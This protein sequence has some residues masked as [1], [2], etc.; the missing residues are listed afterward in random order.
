MQ[1]TIETER[2]VDGRWIAEVVEISGA[3][4]YGDTEQDAIARVRAMALR[5]LAD[6]I[7]HGESATRT[8]G[9]LDCPELK[10]LAQP[11]VAK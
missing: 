9:R 10:C 8:A 7:E 4:V 1:F 3:L 5:I 2:E 6:R 11:G